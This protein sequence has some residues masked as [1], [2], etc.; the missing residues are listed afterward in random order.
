[1][2]FIRQNVVIESYYMNY[3]CNRLSYLIS[4]AGKK[5]IYK[6]KIKKKDNFHKLAWYFFQSFSMVSNHAFMSMYDRSEKR[7]LMKKIR[8]FHQNY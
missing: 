3:V 2:I 5:Q 1:M 6:E 8:N 7:N 4:R